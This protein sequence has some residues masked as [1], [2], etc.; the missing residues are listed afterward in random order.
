MNGSADTEGDAGRKVIAPRE[1]SERLDR[2][3]G[4]MGGTWRIGVELR[5]KDLRLV[6]S[7]CNGGETVRVSD[8]TG[9]IEVLNVRAFPTATALDRCLNALNAMGGQQ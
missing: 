5:Y 6:V 1:K 8:S 7:G 2:L 3:G 9:L 4:L